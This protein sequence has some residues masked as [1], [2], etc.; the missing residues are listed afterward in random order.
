M[1]N[2]KMLNLDELKQYIVLGLDK[3]GNHV[4]AQSQ[5]MTLQDFAGHLAR[6]QVSVDIQVGISAYKEANNE[7]FVPKSKTMDT[8]NL[9]TP[10]KLGDQSAEAEG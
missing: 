4:T 10:P 7:M 2:K 8:P 6:A 1:D 5:N 9:W 3:D